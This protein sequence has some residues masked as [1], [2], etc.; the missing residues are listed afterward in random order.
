MVSEYVCFN[1]KN[2]MIDNQA[3]KIIE[4]VCSERENSI[5]IDADAEAMLILHRLMENGFIVAKGYTNPNTKLNKDNIP[6]DKMNEF[7][8]KIDELCYDYEYELYPT[9]EGWTGKLT[10]NN[11]NESF[12]CIGNNELLSWGSWILR[13]TLSCIANS[14]PTS[15]SK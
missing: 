7:L 2:I 8:S 1:D 4:Q 12:A 10:S 11:E 5:E 6:S 15:I 3:K 13:L 14:L 9:I